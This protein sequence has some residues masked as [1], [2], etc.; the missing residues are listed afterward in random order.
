MDLRLCKLVK[1]AV[2]WSS[3]RI[4][5][6]VSVMRMLDRGATENFGKSN[7][8]FTCKWMRDEYQGN[9]S[10]WKAFISYLVTLKWRQ[11]FSATWSKFNKKTLLI[12]NVPSKDDIC[13][14]LRCLFIKLLT[15]IFF[16]FHYVLLRVYIAVESLSLSCKCGGR[17]LLTMHLNVISYTW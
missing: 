12:T 14:K 15:K 4:L 6:W 3:L 9:F 16:W 17:Y 13:A 5:V 11:C 8:L 1:W 10:N 7:N 2:F